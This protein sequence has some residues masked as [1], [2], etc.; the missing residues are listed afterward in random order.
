MKIECKNL[1][2]TKKLAAS[3]AKNLPDEGCFVSLY[4]DIGAGKTAFV[5]FVLKELGVKDK[6]TSPS[7]VILNEYLNYR[8]PIYH[9]DL[10]RLEKE[11]IKTITEELSDYSKRNI[12]TFVEWADFGSDALSLD[13]LDIKILYP[14]VLEYGENGDPRV[15]EFIPS[16]SKNEVFVQKIIET[17]EAQK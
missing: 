11:G 3:F 14:D 16:G 2:D 6:V 13:R 10:Y 9:F 17:Y 15:F 4:G 7:F 5:R 12:L 1:D 8:I